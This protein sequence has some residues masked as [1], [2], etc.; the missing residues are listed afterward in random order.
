VDNAAEALEVDAD[1]DREREGENSDPRL[2]L[3]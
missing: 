3:R 2:S 1:A